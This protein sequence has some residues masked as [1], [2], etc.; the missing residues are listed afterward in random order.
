MKKYII[1]QLTLILSCTLH[2]QDVHFSQY[3]QTPSLVNPALT[4]SSHVIRATVIYRDQWRSVTVPYKT[5]G[6]SFEM[7]FK[8]SNW[9]KTDKFKTKIYKQSF[10]R[11]AGGLSFFRDRAGDGNMGT[12]QLNA[13]LATFIPTGKYSSLSAGL[14]GS[15]V[16][17]TI[18][19][20]KLTFLNQ[21]SGT[22][23]DPSLSSNENY[24]SQN[25]V[26]ADFAGG[27]NWSYGFNERAI[28]ANNEK[29]A[30]IGVAIYHFNQP[31]LQYLT[32]KHDRLNAKYI[33]H[34]DALL[35]IRNTNV[36]LMPSYIFQMQGPSFEMIEGFMVKY[37]FRENSKYTGIIKKSGIALGAAFRNMDA[38]IVQGMFEY[39]NYAL[40]LSYDLNVSKLTTA[41][42]GRGGFEICIRYVTPN[43][44]LYQKS[45]VR[46]H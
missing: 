12:T 32:D 35:G 29:R 15:F 39:E 36:A 28:G 18:D 9:E 19:F 11:L 4:G 41:S 13:S 44:F 42:T 20:T 8:A 2:S 33:F 24:A 46:F 7:K 5:Y 26:Y 40:G 16:Q 3:Q 45:S 17:Q 1:L 14:Q 6:A 37:Y 22:G 30:N 31:K 25:F 21:Y 10:S 38:L 34:A 27:I 43:P 23:Y